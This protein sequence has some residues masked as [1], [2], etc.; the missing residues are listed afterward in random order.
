MTRHVNAAGFNLVKAQENTKLKSYPD[1]RGIWTIGTGHTG[2]LIPIGINDVVR[3][4]LTITQDQSDILL[5]HDLTTAEDAVDRLVTVPLTDNQFAALVDFTFNE[6]EGELA[7]ST[8]LR[9]LNKGHYDQVPIQLDRWTR[10][11]S[12]ILQD[13]IDRRAAEAALWKTPDGVSI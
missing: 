8:L 11:G 13:L 5:Y 12:E 4:G 9:L 10:A 1:R 2:S 7:G 3:P 6:G